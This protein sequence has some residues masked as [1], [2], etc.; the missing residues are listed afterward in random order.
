MDSEANER[1]AAVI[2]APESRVTV[3]VT[4]TDEERMIAL[5]TGE[6]LDRPA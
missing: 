1:H 3:G 2:R 5:H 4:P 6:M